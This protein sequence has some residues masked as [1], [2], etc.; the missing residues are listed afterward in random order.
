MKGWLTINDFTVSAVYFWPSLSD[1]PRSTSCLGSLPRSNCKAAVLCVISVS[2]FAFEISQMA[3]D[4]LETSWCSCKD[5]S[6]SHPLINS[7]SDLA[8]RVIAACL[9]SSGLTF[10]M[11]IRAVM[12]TPFR[13]RF[14]GK[15]LQGSYTFLPSIPANA[16]RPI[17]QLKGLYSNITPKKNHCGCN[18]R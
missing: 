15:L 11:Y 5:W 6:Q 13:E 16:I 14:I 8:L 3:N 1:P 12:H 4:Y 7:K 2:Q 17:R 9:R 10:G 18:K